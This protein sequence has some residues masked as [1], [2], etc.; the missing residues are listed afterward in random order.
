MK[1]THGQGATEYLIIL[2]AVLVVALIA[3]SLIAGFLPQSGTLSTSQYKSYWTSAQPFGIVDSV[4]SSDK[5][6]TL[7]V[8]NNAPR[9][10]TV[11]NIALTLVADSS[12]NAYF[13]SSTIF[14][15]GQKRNLD[16]PTSVSLPSC[17]GG[18]SSNL[19]HV[20]ITYD[21]DTIAGKI[22]GGNLP[23]AVDCK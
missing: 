1:N 12:S 10:L 7:V 13:S 3:V 16:F 19:M 14:M 4:Q 8:Q 23:L 18:S 2:A 11:R 17:T 5:N 20:S 21:D 9:E 15:A 22:Q 6:I